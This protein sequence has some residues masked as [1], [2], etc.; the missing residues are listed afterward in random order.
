[1]R[2]KLGLSVLLSMLVLGC[3]G[4]PWQPTSEAPP[5]VV[6]EPII[7]A[8]AKPVRTIAGL[9]FDLGMGPPNATSAQNVWMGATNSVRGL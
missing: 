6:S 7:G 9:M 8:P 2:G 3:S 4:E 5:S 1:M